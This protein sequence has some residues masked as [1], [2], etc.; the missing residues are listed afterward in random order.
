ML[1]KKKLGVAQ[2]TS[3]WRDGARG[4]LAWPRRSQQYC[5]LRSKGTRRILTDQS[6][7]RR[8]RRDVSWTCGIPVNLCWRDLARF[9]KFPTA[10]EGQD[11]GHRR[12]DA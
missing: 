8:S 2:Q 6:G 3:G 1:F 7:S 10:L 11:G 9:R 4:L 5:T 12:A